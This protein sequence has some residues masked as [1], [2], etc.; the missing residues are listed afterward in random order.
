MTEA[1]IKFV[2][3]ANMW[4]VTS[5]PEGKQETKYFSTEKEAKEYAKNK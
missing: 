3:K 1:I 2:K 4:C 5:Y